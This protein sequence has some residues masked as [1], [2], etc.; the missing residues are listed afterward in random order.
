[1][2]GCGGDRMEY[3]PLRPWN[4]PDYHQRQA[5]RLRELASIATTAA[6]KARLLQE[7][8]KQE[9]M[10]RGESALGAMNE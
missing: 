10:A 8:E 4:V 5:S 7:A 3:E 1:M 6:L 9:Q 2:I